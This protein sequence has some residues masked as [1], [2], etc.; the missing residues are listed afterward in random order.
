M[1]LSFLLVKWPILG[2]KPHY[3]GVNDNDDAEADRL[4]VPRRYRHH[5]PQISV[6]QQDHHPEHPEQVRVPPPGGHPQGERAQEGGAPHHQ[7][8]PAGDQQGQH[9]RLPQDGHRRVRR[10]GPLQLQQQR[11]QVP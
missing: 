3:L 6:V 11:L 4:R 9:R 1:F 5:L 7:L 2:H 10:A 8:G